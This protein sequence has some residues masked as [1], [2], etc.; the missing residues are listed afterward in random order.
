ML[1]VNCTIITVNATRDII[2]DGAIAVADDIIVAIGKTSDLI[3][4]YGEDERIDLSSHIVM[5]GLISLHVHLAQSLLRTAADDLPLIEWLCDRVWCMQGCFTEEDGYVASKL[6]IAEMLKSGTTTFVESLFA[7]RY[8]FGGAV[9][10]VVE[11]G[12]RGCLGKVV[13]DQPR[14]ATQ[15]GISMHPGL[16][17]DERSLDNAVKCHQKYHGDGDG[18]V[19]V[20]FGAR[21]PGGVSEDLYRRMITM[22]RQNDIGITM[23]CAEVKADR[24]FFASNG[25]TP[26]TYCQDLGLLAPRTVLAH[27]V[28]LDDEDIKILAGTGASVGHC[29][30][31][32]AKLGSGVCRVKELLEH[33]VP[34]GIGC[35]GCP[36]NNTMDLLQ[37]MKMASLMPKAIHGDPSLVP[38]EK[39]IEMATII[40]AKALGKDHEI[41]SIEVGKKADFISINLTDKLYAQPMRD[42][43][44]MVVYIATGSDVDTVVVD[45]KVV[46]QQGKLLTIDEQKL[47]QQA[48]IHGEA[49]RERAGIIVDSRWPVV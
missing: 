14:Y 25:H 20:W 24:E 18:R 9:K 11:S 33:D 36:C 27:M 38:A 10:A 48:N 5:P 42:P 29:P 44:S 22:A 30:T 6:T 35:D 37:E 2:K 39:I 41:G 17:E 40:G 47:I 21:T 23:H 15:E 26:M 8:G 4:Q 7:E 46:V 1:F 31:S 43:V 49:V 45:G 34:V 32:N 3:Q 19:E 28:H 16:I 12:I 13:M